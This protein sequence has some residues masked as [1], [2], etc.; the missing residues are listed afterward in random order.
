MEQC[1]D[2]PGSRHCARPAAVCDI[3]L[4]CLASKR[5]LAAWG[6]VRYTLAVDRLSPEAGNRMPAIASCCHLR[7]PG[8]QRGAAEFHSPVLSCCCK[9]CVQNASTFQ[10]NPAES[11]QHFTWLPQQATLQGIPFKRRHS[12]WLRLARDC[13]PHQQPH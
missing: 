9:A 7:R 8:C 2:L 1:T 5:A 12:V 11:N 3:A 4:W 13:P 6:E 10:C